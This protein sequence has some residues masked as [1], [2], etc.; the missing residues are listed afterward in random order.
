MDINNRSSSLSKEDQT[1]KISKS[2]FVTNFPEHFT[3]RDLWNVCLAYGNIIDVFIPFKRS[4]AG[5]KFAFVFFI[6]V[7]KLYR[8]I[9]I[10]STIW[11]GR[12][13]LHANVVRFQKE[14]KTNDVQ[15]IINDSQPNKSFVG[16]VKNMG[17]ENTSFA[18]V[19]NTGRGNSNKVIDSSPTIV[20]DDECLMKHDFSW[21]LMGKIKD[22]NALPNL[23]LILS[24]KGFE[25]VKFTYLDGLWV[26]LDMDTI[27]SKENPQIDFVQP[28][29]QNHHLQVSSNNNDIGAL[30]TN[31]DKVILD[32]NDPQFPPGFTPNVGKVNVEEMNLLSL[33]IQGLGNKAKK[34]WI[35]ELN[36]KHRVS[37]VAIQ[38]TKMKNI[39]LFSINVLWGNFAFDYAFS[40]SLGYSGGILCAWDPNLFHKDNSIVSYSF[41]AIRGTWIPSATKILIISIYASQDLNEKVMLW[42]FLGH[43]IDTWDGEYVLLGDFN[44]VR[45][46]NERHGTVFYANGANAFDNFITMAG[47]V[48][49]PLE[50]Y[51]FTL[52][53]KSASKMSKLDRFLI[54]EGLLTSF[55]SLSALCLD[56]HLSVH[57]PILMRELKVDYGP[58]PFRLF[59]SWFYK[60]GFDKMENVMKL[61]SERSKLSKELHDINSSASL[62]MF[63]KEKIHE[64][65]WIVDPSNV[66]NVFLNHF[67]N[68]FDKP[69]SP[70]LLLESQFPNVLTSDQLAD[71][72][73]DVTHEEFKKAVWD[74]VINKSPGPDVK[75][76]TWTQGRLN[77]AM[78]SI[79]VNGSPTS[80]FKFY[81]GLK[82]GDPLSPFLFILIMESLH[83]SFKN[84]VNAGLYKGLPIDSLLTLSHLFYA[85]DA[86]FVGK[87][88][89]QNIA[90][91]V[92]VLKYVLSAVESIGCSI[93][94]APFNFLGVKVGGLML[95]RSSWEEVIDR[96][97]ALIGWDKIMA[98]KKNGGLGVSSF[99]PLTE[100]LFS[101]GFGVLSLTAHPYWLVSLKT[102]MARK[103]LL[104]ILIIFPCAALLG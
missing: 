65:D 11:I 82:Q 47:L 24:N 37:F 51:S 69:I 3:T 86:V 79:L 71:L 13:R 91:L 60:K 21:S 66:K 32:N 12:L 44:E 35:R 56:R 102:F 7:D 75:W 81:K 28:Q 77:Y 33:N 80:E 15:P 9:E 68:R 49:L 25:N 30:D 17:V 2:V 67:S 52:S 97:L 41:V 36:T 70:K 29:E 43:M 23:Y 78:G 84:V 54:S 98:S 95:R 16:S 88:D 104:I 59:H 73:R 18:S 8:L 10:L 101:N 103:E 48:D 34:G 22:I 64:G 89:K 42:E 76:R 19:L 62:D 100:L 74:C 31:K 63:Q 5:K 85:D 87:W 90:T 39:D 57:R 61:V 83:L 40:L 38:E 55:P 94:A 92:N 4:K 26:L 46:S 99:F 53:H 58:T 14:P 45:S 72:E 96:R 1:Q 50:G 6:R 93:F 27:E 20:L